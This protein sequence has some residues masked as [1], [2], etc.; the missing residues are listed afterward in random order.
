MESLKETGIPPPKTE[1]QK[2]QAKINWANKAAK[3]LRVE[4]KNMKRISIL[5]NTASAFKE[6]REVDGRYYQA[7]VIV[8][9]EL[10]EKE[11]RRRKELSDGTIAFEDAHTSLLDIK[12]RQA[13]LDH[14]WKIIGP[15]RRE[16]I[17]QDVYGVPED[18]VASGVA[19]PDR[20]EPP[21]KGFEFSA[22]K[23]GG[24]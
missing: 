8:S 12:T 13:I 11:L 21:S 6:R 9:N 5:E 19:P 1:R 22:T 2:A 3:T 14:H 18:A 23:Y 24:S 4:K 15:D 20:K 7:R 10:K 16:H 17:V